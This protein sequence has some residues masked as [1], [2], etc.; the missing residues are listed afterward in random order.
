MK[1]LSHFASLALA[2]LG[3]TLRSLKAPLQ[4]WRPQRAPVLVPIPIRAEQRAPS[5]AKRLPYRGG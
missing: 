5:A 1:L 4:G 2:R 3:Q